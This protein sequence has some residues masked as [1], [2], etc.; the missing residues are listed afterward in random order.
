MI[1]VADPE[2]GGRVLVQVWVLKPTA[3]TPRGD[4]AIF[5]LVKYVN[6]GKPLQI[7]RTILLISF[8]ESVVRKSFD[9]FSYGSGC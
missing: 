2:C 1:A 8:F 6:A 5:L 7:L 9:T 3:K 4:R